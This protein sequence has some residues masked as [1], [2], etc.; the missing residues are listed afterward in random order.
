[1]FVCEV[2]IFLYVVHLKHKLKKR[3]GPIFQEITL[4]ILG[5][6]VFVLIVDKKNMV[7]NR[8]I[9]DERFIKKK[10]FSI[11]IEL[12]KIGQMFTK[13]LGKLFKDKITITVLNIIY[14]MLYRYCIFKEF[15]SLIRN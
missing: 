6:K 15:V 14:Y 4:N 2:G 10:I 8:N 9:S 12:E 5:R 1:M 13:Q 3:Y 7:E 11:T